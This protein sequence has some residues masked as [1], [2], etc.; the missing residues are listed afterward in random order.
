MDVDRPVS[1]QRRALISAFATLSGL[2]LLSPRAAARASAVG[3]RFRDDPFVAGIASGSPSPDGFVLWTRLIAPE[4]ADAGP[5]PVR[6]EVFEDAAGRRVIARGEAWAEPELGHAVHVEVAGLRSDTWYGYRFMVGDAVSA[7]GRT[8]TAPAPGAP[9]DRLRL[10]LASCQ[11][12]ES[13]HYAAYRH[14]HAE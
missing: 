6:W 5:V 4:L 1:S 12:W 2:A 8:R 3:P 13:G 7:W 9:V 11:R 10:A 14:M